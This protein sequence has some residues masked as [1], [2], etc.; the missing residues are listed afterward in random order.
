[1]DSCLLGNDP[2][3]AAAGQRH[4]VHGYPTVHI[5]DSSVITAN[6]GINPALTVAAMAERAWAL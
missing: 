5:T 1:M 3:T 4:R 6:L 2:R